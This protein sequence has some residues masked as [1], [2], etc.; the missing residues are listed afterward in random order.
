VS[1]VV[2]EVVAHEVGHATGFIGHDSNQ[3]VMHATGAHDVANPSEVSAEVCRRARSGSVLAKASSKDCCPEGGLSRGAKTAIGVGGG[4]LL[5]AGIGALAGG[6]LGG[7]VGA[8]IG[9]LVGGLGSLL[10]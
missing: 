7:A 1:G 9:A 4:A 6:P 10:F 5:G 3:T 8:G 2:P